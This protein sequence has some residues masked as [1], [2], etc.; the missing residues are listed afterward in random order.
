LNVVKGL[1]CHVIDESAEQF[2]NV[3]C[4]PRLDGSGL[5]PSVFD[6]VVQCVNVLAIGTH[7]E[8]GVLAMQ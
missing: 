8:V 3:A 6:R 4:Q 1:R 7:V 5:D 2:S